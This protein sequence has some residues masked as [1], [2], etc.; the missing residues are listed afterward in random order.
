MDG[1]IAGTVVSGGVVGIHDDGGGVCGVD[2]VGDVVVDEV[3]DVAAYGG[4][5]DVDGVDGVEYS[6]VV[7]STGV[8]IYVFCDWS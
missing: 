8:A 1:V 4:V 2:G 3:V 5:D 6:V 7:G